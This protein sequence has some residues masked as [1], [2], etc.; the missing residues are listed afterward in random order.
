MAWSWPRVGARRPVFETTL[1]TRNALPRDDV[2]MELLEPIGLQARC[3]YKAIGWD[4][5]L[6]SWPAVAQNIVRHGPRST[7][8]RERSPGYTKNTET[9][10]KA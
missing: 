9:S 6:R 5:N 10:P 3:P 8:I 1:P 4:W 2:R 7:S